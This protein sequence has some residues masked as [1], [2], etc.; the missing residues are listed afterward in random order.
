MD[1]EAT[2]HQLCDVRDL[3]LALLQVLAK[4]LAPGRFTPQVKIPKSMPQ[5]DVLTHLFL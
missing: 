1:A 2:S 5:A 4:D 3:C